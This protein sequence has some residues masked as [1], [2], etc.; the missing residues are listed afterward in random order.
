[1]RLYTYK[2][3]Y[4]GVDF[5]FSR[6]SKKAA[7]AAFNNNL[8]VVFCPVNLRPG[9]PWR[10]DVVI[11]KNDDPGRTFDAALNA[12]EFYNCNLPETGKYTAF[13]I[14]VRGVSYFSDYDKKYDITAYNYDFIEAVRPTGEKSEG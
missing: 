13:Y 5:V 14:P 8:P 2:D 6:I 3:N 10:P 7:R 9:G 11:C 12:F 4:R 1:M